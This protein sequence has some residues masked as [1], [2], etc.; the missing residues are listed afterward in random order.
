MEGTNEPGQ[1]IPNVLAQPMP[2]T[3]EWHASVQVNPD[4]RKFIVVKLVSA[5]FPSPDPQAWQDKR[6]H[7]LVAYAKKTEANIY[8][9]A[10]SKSE[11]YHL[12][13][14]K[15]LKIQKEMEEK[16]KSRKRRL[17]GQPGQ[18]DEPGP[19]GASAS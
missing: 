17:D 5:L 3:K 18:P 6:M 16:R 9:N 2:N 19:S 4:H 10:T 1:F 8:A 15:I 12:L 7:N 11:Y 13:A 14:D